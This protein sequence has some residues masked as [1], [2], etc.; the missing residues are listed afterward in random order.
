ML[1]MPICK[2]T[3]SGISI[4]VAQKIIRRHSIISG[5]NK[6]HLLLCPF[7]SESS[8]VSVPSKTEPHLALNY[9]SSHLSTLVEYLTK[10]KKGKAIKIAI[11]VKAMMFE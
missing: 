2:A 8:A 5:K 4:T 11:T 7:S 10:M 1:V 3:I 6:A 9:S